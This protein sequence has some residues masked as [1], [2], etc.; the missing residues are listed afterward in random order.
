MRVCARVYAGICSSSAHAFLQVWFQNRRAKFR[1]NERN[2]LAQRTSLYGAH[3]MEPQRSP[4]QP[5]SA[6]PAPLNVGADDLGWSTGLGGYSGLPNGSAAPAPS[7]YSCNSLPS[8]SPN[9]TSPVNSSSCAYS[10]TNCATP[11]SAP[12]PNMPVLPYGNNTQ[13]SAFYQFGLKTPDY[14]HQRQYM[15]SQPMT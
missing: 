8:P 1:R 6:R 14:L 9:Q 5:I 4:E 2:L 10:R 12:L 15:L 7:P 13:A 3:Q 11:P